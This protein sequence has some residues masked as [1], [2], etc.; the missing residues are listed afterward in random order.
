MKNFVVLLVIFG[1]LI[2]IIQATNPCHSA[3][4]PFSCNGP[5]ESH[6]HKCAGNK[7]FKFGH[8]VCKLGYFDHGAV[9]CGSNFSF[10]CLQ[11][12]VNPDGS[13]QC[14]KCKHSV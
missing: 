6:C 10:D 8:C 5:L 1:R 4:E 2:T 13:V 14:T 7:E 9:Q 11:G 3:C 12:T